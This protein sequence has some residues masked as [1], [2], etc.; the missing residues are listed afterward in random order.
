MLSRERRAPRVQ[1]VGPG[2]GRR[3]RKVAF[4]VVDRPQSEQWGETTAGTCALARRHQARARGTPRGQRVIGGRWTGRP[5]H[6]P[7]HEARWRPGG[8][9]QPSMKMLRKAVGKTPA[10]RRPPLPSRDMP[11]RGVDVPS[12]A[13]IGTDGPSS[14]YR[15]AARHRQAPWREF[16]PGPPPRRHGR[17][18]NSI[19][20]RRPHS[21]PEGSARGA[22][23]RKLQ[24]CRC[25][26]IGGGFP[27]WRRQTRMRIS[28][29]QRQGRAAAS[30]RCNTCSS[31]GCRKTKWRAW[32]FCPSL[33]SSAGRSLTIVV[34]RDGSRI[35]S[36]IPAED[37]RGTSPPTSGACGIRWL[38]W[39]WN[40]P[41]PAA[42]NR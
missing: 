34:E 2:L 14:A 38:L 40:E 31:P 8:G 33:E 20:L 18:P 9:R 10:K 4:A 11:G 28:F 25:R 26:Q 3:A 30:R 37:D 36:I 21:R 27:A 35:A 32:N 19:T 42:M 29:A 1:P 22:A 13:G 7:L 41:L 6:P 17:P 15:A 23:R 24:P 16:R 39:E 12:R 5:C